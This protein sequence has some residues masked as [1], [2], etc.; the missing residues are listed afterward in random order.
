[1]SVAEARDGVPKSRMAD[2]APELF[3]RATPVPGWRC[4]WNRLAFWAIA[5]AWVCL[6]LD[7]DRATVERVFVGHD[8][9]TK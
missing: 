6:N 1:M 2:L 9:V 8:Y 7:D 3:L 5:P 4:R